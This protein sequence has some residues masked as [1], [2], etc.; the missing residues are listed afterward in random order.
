MNFSKLR[1]NMYQKIWISRLMMAGLTAAI[2]LLPDVSS[3]QGV[4]NKDAKKKEI[5]PGAAAHLSVV[6]LGPIPTRRYKMPDDD[7]LEDIESEGDSES[8][9]DGGNKSKK[10]RPAADSGAGGIPLLLPPL[11]GAVPP[12][13]LFYKL[14]KAA[15]GGNPWARMRVGF[16]NATSV[17]KVHA[18]VP[19][20]LHYIDRDKNSGYRSYLK[21]P[22]L[23]PWSQVVVFLTPSK[24]G[25]TPWKT[26]PTI[27]VLNL[28]SQALRDK[29]VLVRNFSSEPVAFV[30]DDNA[31]VTLKSGQRR[32]FNI[33][34]KAGFH[35]VAAIK[36]N[37]KV[38][39]LNTSVRVPANT[40]NLFAFYNAEPQTNGGK[41]IGAFRTTLSRLSPAELAK[42][43]TAP[44]P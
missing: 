39:L 25:K 19:L 37:G 17:S 13:T 42:K 32:S 28:R 23:E 40:L 44:K 14:P 43:M 2:C 26:E 27:S 24:D 30:I 12:S 1:G 38:R 11:A 6:A 36:V 9:G 7:D 34:R 18:G 29:N 3:A 10:N 41:N 22:P 16:N 5:P 15:K 20:D 35:R 4:K 21:L 31:P 33:A 8:G